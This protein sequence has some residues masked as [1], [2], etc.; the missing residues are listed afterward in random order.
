MNKI[1]SGAAIFIAALFCVAI[2]SPSQE[3]TGRVPVLL[4]LFT[5]EGCSSCPPADK[6]LQKLD[7]DQP[8][9]GADLI[10]LSEHVDYWNH[11]GWVD[12]Y[13]SRQFSQRQESYA[14]MLG[15]EA[16][17]PQLVVDGAK[18]VVG[19]NWAAAERA[20]KDSLKRSKLSVLINAERVGDGAR[21]HFE[22]DSR[23]T[24]EPNTV[25]YLVLAA[26]QPSSHVTR[27]ENAGRDLAH[28]AVAYSFQKIGTA[29]KNADF[30]K[31]VRI[32]LRSPANP[33]G[34]RV[35]VFVQDPATKRVVGVAQARV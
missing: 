27:G 32:A 33:S 14:S 4:E 26:D 1:L 35:I 22:I 17:T 7:Q 24:H 23:N 10:V 3:K 16:Y 6:L 31:D 29:A 15:S 11:L 13:S 20:I 28:V 30:Q 19:G 18:D 25:V 9:D 2:N 12:P 5:S 21:V 34:T 8:V